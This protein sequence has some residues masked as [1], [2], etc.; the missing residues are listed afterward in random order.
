M[1]CFVLKAIKEFEIQFKQIEQFGLDEIDDEARLRDEYEKL[2]RQ[3][4][5]GWRED[6]SMQEKFTR[7]DQE[8]M[9]KLDDL[10][11]RT[12]AREDQ[13]GLVKSNL[14]TGIRMMNEYLGKMSSARNKREAKKKN[15][16]EPVET[17]ITTINENDDDADEKVSEKEPDS[18]LIQHEDR[19]E[20]ETEKREE[21][22]G[23]EKLL[24][25]EENIE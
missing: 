17:T 8:M 4:V 6:M 15:A 18:S 24:V 13:V 22:K 3:L 14:S 21:A 16:S 5:Q 25:A 19:V 11:V 7:D 1:F 12:N 23:E 2:H 9:R 20:E 10:L